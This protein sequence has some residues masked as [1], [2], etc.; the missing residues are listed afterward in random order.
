MIEAWVDVDSTLWPFRPHFISRLS[1]KSG[2]TVIDD[3]YHI[4]EKKYGLTQEDIRTTIDGIFED[5]YLYKPFPDTDIFLYHLMKNCDKVTI[6]SHRDPSWTEGLEEWFHLNDLKTYCNEIICTKAPKHEFMNPEKVNILID[7]AKEVLEGAEGKAH[8]F[9]IQYYYNEN[10]P[11]VHYGKNLSELIPK[12]NS[13]IKGN[14][15]VQSKSTND[16]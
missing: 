3:S 12:I 9:T 5:Q 2:M 11:G 14:N 16:F 1:K 13:I 4:D 6:I 10:I 15:N 8:R 7:D